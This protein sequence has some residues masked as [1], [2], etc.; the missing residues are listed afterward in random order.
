MGTQNAALVATELNVTVVVV[1]LCFGAVSLKSAISA[2]LRRGQDA[3]GRGNATS[4]PDRIRQADD[5]RE[6]LSVTTRYVVAGVSLVTACLLLAHVVPP[7]VAYAVLCLAWASRSVADQIS[8][9]R[10]PRRRAVLLGRSRRVD[11]VLAIWIGLAAV[12]SLL[13]VRWI[14]DEAYR[15]AA[16]LVAVCVVTMVVVS[17]RIVTAPPLLF[18]NDI[19]AEQIVDRETRA[20]R[21]GNTCF[22]AIAAVLFFLLVIG[23]PSILETVVLVLVPFGLMAW[24]TIYARHLSRAPLAS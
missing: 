6:R 19:E 20:I 9:E 21:A 24:K 12:Y 16:I 5:D 15:G 7:T 13:L 22:F 2:S 18:G 17:W 8:E 10:A 23:V 11:P 3:F 14:A 4:Q 1:A